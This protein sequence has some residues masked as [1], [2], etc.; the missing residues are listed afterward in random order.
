MAQAEVN[1]RISLEQYIEIE[2][3]TG[4]RHEYHDGEI[5][6]MAGG[7]FEHGT[8]C[9]NA[10]GILRDISKD[11]GTCRAFTS[12]L[13]IDIAK[14]NKFV[15]PDAMLTCPKANKSKRIAG[16]VTNPTLIVEVLSK[17]SEGYDRGAKF[18]YYFTLPS[19]KEYILVD[20]N[21]PIVTVFRRRGDLTRVY[22]YEGLDEVIP[23]ESIEGQIS[24]LDL[25][26]NVEFPDLPGDEG[27]F[28]Y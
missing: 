7:T 17:S 19:L 25:Y 3:T 20:I 14:L 1:Q 28:S 23:L 26:E 24:M 4:I 6:A 5:F 22:V 21:Q 9:G 18:R 15:Y 27:G 16:A 10:H 2:Q 13:K 12:E 8:I 11:S